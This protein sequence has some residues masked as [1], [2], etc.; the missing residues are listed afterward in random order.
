MDLFFLLDGFNGIF[1]PGCDNWTLC[2]GAFLLTSSLIAGPSS[3]KCILIGS[4][5]NT[6][7]IICAPGG[8]VK[9]KCGLAA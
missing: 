8:N 1:N 3:S 4:P 9:L 5:V 6:S 2:L 7:G